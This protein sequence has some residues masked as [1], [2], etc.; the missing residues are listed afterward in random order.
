MLKGNSGRKKVK[1]KW[2]SV[3][4]AK[5]KTR[6]ITDL[7][8]PHGSRDIPLQSQKFGQDGHRHFVGIQPH[9]HLN[10]TSQTQSCKLMKKWRCNISGVFCFICLK[11]CSL[12]ELSK[13]I[14]LDFKFRCYG[15]QNQNDCLL[16]KKQ[17]VYCLSKSDVQNVV[18][19][20]TVWMLLQVVS[21]FEEKLA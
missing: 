16:L 14:S 20:N 9:F 21:C 4:N 8:A 15:N 2:K 13:G 17:K 3:K 1:P 10:M 12:L 5:K 18:W 11:L 6:A 19:N 7:N